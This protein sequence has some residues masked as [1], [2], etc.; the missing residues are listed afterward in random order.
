[1]QSNRINKN[2]QQCDT[3]LFCG[4]LRLRKAIVSL[5]VVIFS[6]LFSGNVDAQCGAGKISATIQG[7]GAIIKVDNAYGGNTGQNAL[8][9]PDGN[10]AFFSNNGQYIIIDLLDTVKAG[11]IYS[12]IWRQYPGIG[13]AS[14]IWWSESLDGV[15]FVDHPTSG[16]V[17]TTNER[18][19]LSDF[20]A[21]TDTR[22]IR[23][24]MMSGT[25]DF[26]VDA[27]SY[28]ATKCFSDNCGAGYNAQLVSGNGLYLSGNGIGDPNY[29]SYSP[30]GK[31]ALLNSAGDW[32]RIRL[33]Y[34]ISAGQEYYVI[35]RP[36][37]K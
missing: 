9:G 11:Q 34:T 30:D 21:A 3:R 16:S 8:G 5:L 28:Y 7:F 4:R 14:Q 24:S 10:G 23:I 25:N 29:I 36:C 35:W 18:Y 12:F 6:L 32:I 19:F 37:R 27:I 17:S 13:P 33:P 31:G 22:Y 1:M 20:S 26:N 15:T 2:G